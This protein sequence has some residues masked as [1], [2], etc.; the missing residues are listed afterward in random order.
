MLERESGKYL[1]TQNQTFLNNSQ[2][3]DEMSMKS[4]EFLRLDDDEALHGEFVGCIKCST[5]KLMTL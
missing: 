5:R 3:K 4:R 2:V 1:S